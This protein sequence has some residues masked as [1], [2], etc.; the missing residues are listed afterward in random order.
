[1]EVRSENLPKL[2]AL[3]RELCNNE[4]KDID[5][6]IN[7]YSL[8]YNNYGC[9]NLSLK[10]NWKFY[11]CRNCCKNNNVL[12]CSKCFNLNDHIGHDIYL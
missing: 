1:M 6:F 7:F 10:D 11:Y 4:F 8:N 5:D 9:L 3:E 2:D 12:Y